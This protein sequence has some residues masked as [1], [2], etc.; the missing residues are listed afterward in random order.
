MEPSKGRLTQM[1]LIKLR[2]KGM[3]RTM[4]IIEVSSVSQRQT[5]RQCVTV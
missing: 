1:A 4:T 2:T 5:S 3:V